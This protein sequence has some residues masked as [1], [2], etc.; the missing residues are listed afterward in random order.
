MTTCPVQ[1][2]PNSLHG[3]LG[4]GLRKYYEDQ[5]GKTQDLCA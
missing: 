4:S 2:S 3:P 5:L 1:D